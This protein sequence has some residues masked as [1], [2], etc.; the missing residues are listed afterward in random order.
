MGDQRKPVVHPSDHK[1]T[2]RRGSRGRSSDHFSDDMTSSYRSRSISRSNQGT[3]SVGLESTDASKPKF[4]EKIRSSSHHRSMGT[5]RKDLDSERSGRLK[6]AM[7]F[8][9]HERRPSN[10]KKSPGDD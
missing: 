1:N 5:I 3:Q 7:S 10:K 4:G 9:T 2:V 6:R 8:S